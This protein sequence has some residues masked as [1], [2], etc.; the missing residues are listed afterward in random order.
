[1]L[2]A[3]GSL[4]YYDSCEQYHYKLT[5]NFYLN[6]IDYFSKYSIIKKHDNDYN[7]IVVNVEEI[8][9]LDSA[10][11][12]KFKE[13]SVLKYLYLSPL[14]DD[15]IITDNINDIDKLVLSQSIIWEKP[16]QIV[17]VET[18]N[19]PVKL[20]SQILLMLIII[21]GLYIIIRKFNLKRVAKS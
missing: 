10:Y 2:V 13:N 21:L 9:S 17:E 19:N 11:L 16:W 18:L 4:R 3:Y 20:I 6:K 7:T 8:S 15:C 12:I 14:S 5:E 1:L